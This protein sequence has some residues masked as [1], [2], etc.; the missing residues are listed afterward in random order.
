LPWAP[1]IPPDRYP[2]GRRPRRPNHVWNH[3]FVEGHTHDG[4]K[5]RLLNVLDQFTQEWLDLWVGR[6]LKAAVVIHL[7]S[8]LFIL[9]GVPRHVRYL[10]EFVAKAV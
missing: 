3:D 1:T 4:R 10:P 9:R 7:L 2:V 5:F 6:K 8:D